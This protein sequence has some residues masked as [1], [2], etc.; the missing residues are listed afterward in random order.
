MLTGRDRYMMPV[1][2][3]RVRF[4][5]DFTT[6]D[7]PSQMLLADSAYPLLNFLMTAVLKPEDQLTE[8]EKRFNTSLRKSRF[9][10]ENAFGILKSRF[11]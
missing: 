8:S 1:F 4:S 2:F 10:V 11:L 5:G 9:V 7:V 3:V 6:V